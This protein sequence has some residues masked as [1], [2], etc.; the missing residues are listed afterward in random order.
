MFP[1]TEQYTGL[2]S[3]FDIGGKAGQLMP[4]ATKGK[5]CQQVN[6]FGI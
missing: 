1:D 5:Q 3:P 2:R 4:K 6:M